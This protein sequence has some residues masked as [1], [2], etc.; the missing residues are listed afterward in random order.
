[1]KLGSYE[2]DGLHGWKFCVS[3]SKR[4]MDLTNVLKKAK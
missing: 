1:M 2:L 3:Q 4:K